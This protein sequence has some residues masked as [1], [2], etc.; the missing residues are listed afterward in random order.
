MSA[1]LEE[2]VNAEGFW[3]TFKS[4]ATWTGAI[5][6]ALATYAGLPY[7]FPEALKVGGAAVGGAATG[8]AA[9][10]GGDGLHYVAEKLQ[11]TP[12]SIAGGLL[13]GT[14]V[15]LATLTAFPLAYGLAAFNFLPGYM[16]GSNADRIFNYTGNLIQS[17]KKNVKSLF[18]DEQ[19]KARFSLY[20]K[21]GS[22]E[23]GFKYGGLFG[24]VGALSEAK[25]RMSNYF[26][27]YFKWFKEGFAPT[28][29][30]APARG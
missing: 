14:G 20:S 3:P 18:Y 8:L 23:Q 6:G 17:A 2:R 26:G 5:A 30:P 10:I 29:A 24:V 7:H 9:K 16:L 21:S 13:V 19:G 22:A 11:S 4:V 1:N 12:T 15:A 25:N 27:N 28:P